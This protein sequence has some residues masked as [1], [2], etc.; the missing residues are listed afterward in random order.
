MINYSSVNCGIVSIA[1]FAHT[2]RDDIVWKDDWCETEVID[3]SG[4]SVSD[5]TG[6]VSVWRHIVNYAHTCTDL[7]QQCSWFDSQSFAFIELVIS[8]NHWQCDEGVSS[9]HI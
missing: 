9:A 8:S 4:R 2:D 5:G 1:H 6:F 3:L 7:Q